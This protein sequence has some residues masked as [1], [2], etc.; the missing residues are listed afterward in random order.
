MTKSIYKEYF[1][2]QVVLRKTCSYSVPSVSLSSRLTIKLNEN[3]QSVVR[4]QEKKVSEEDMG[5]T[6]KEFTL[7]ACMLL[8]CKS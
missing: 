3:Q 8:V 2:A 6:G 7:N 1:L 4:L 5:F